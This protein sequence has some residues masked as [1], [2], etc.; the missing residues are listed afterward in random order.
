MQRD[1]AAFGSPAA[2]RIEQFGGKVQA[3]C[4]GGD[5]AWVACVDCLVAF[6][7]VEKGGGF[8]LAFDI[9]WEGDFADAVDIFEEV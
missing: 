7:V 4:G 9:G 6:L 1:V 3:G 5:G 8:L 2:D